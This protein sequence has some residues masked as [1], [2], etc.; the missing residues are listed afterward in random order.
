[1][2]PLLDTRSKAQRSSLGP[3]TPGPRQQK[4]KGKMARQRTVGRATD[5]ASSEHRGH[6]SGPMGAGRQ[7][8]WEGCQHREL[9]GTTASSSGRVRVV[10]GR[11]GCSRPYY[12]P[13]HRGVQRNSPP[14]GR[15]GGQVLTQQE[16]ALGAQPR[17]AGREGARKAPS[18]TGSGGLAGTGLEPLSARPWAWLTDRLLC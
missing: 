18:L 7:L 1:M 11:A 4:D 12:G 2:R 16:P 13:L 17:P 3:Q 15:A 6:R 9:G 8:Q 10:S 14:P 5:T